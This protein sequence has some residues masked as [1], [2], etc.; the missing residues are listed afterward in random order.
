MLFIGGKTHI[1]INDHINVK[2]ND[3]LH[4]DYVEPDELNDLKIDDTVPLEC[5]QKLKNCFDEF[6]VIPFRPEVP[7]CNYEMKIDVEQNHVSF[8]YRPRRLSYAEKQAV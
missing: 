4:I 6:Y 3:M 5:R 7:K 2:N 8:S 1:E